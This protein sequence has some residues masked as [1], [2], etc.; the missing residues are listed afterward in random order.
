VDRVRPTTLAAERRES[1]EI[2]TDRSPVLLH[3]A[4]QDASE[5]YDPRD[6]V[7]DD[8]DIIAAWMVAAGI[9]VL[10]FALA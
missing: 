4:H 8:S 1:A 6:H 3:A 5:R 7:V 9:F 10:L 2:E